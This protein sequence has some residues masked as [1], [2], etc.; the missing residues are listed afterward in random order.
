MSKKLLLPEDVIDWLSRRYANQHKA[1]LLGSG[2]W[3]MS[4][5]LGIPTERDV[6]QDVAGVRQ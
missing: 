4:V 5:N 1:W 6:A 2:Q 3:P